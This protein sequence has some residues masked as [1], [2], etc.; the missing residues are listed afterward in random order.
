MGVQAEIF[1]RSLR[2]VLAAPLS[3]IYAAGPNTYV[4]ARGPEDRPL[5]RQVTLG[6]SNETH[7]QILTGLE[8]G[9]EIL[10]LQ[11]GQGQQLLAAAGIKV[12]GPAAGGADTADATTQPATRPAE[13]PSVPVADGPMVL[14]A[15]R[16][17]TAPAQ[18][19]R[20]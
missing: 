17:T 1:V 10:A 7:A 3:C 11:M 19:G 4:F 13:T 9:Q 8:A 20:M 2:G 15:R 6:E 16:T 12:Q 18:N 14:G 5:P